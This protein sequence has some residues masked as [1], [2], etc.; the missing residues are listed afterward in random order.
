M[1][2]R[3]LIVALLALFACDPSL[4][5]THANTS[6]QNAG[7]PEIVDSRPDLKPS[8]ATKSDTKSGSEHKEEQCHYDGPHWFAG[9]YCFFAGHDKFWVSF[10]TLVL[11]AFTTIL[12]FATIFLTRAT[13][14]LVSGAEQ[15]SKRQ[16]RAYIGLIKH[17][18][19]FDRH[20]FVITIKNTGQTPGLRVTP[21][22]NM[23]WYAPGQQ[24]PAHFAFA[25]YPQVEGSGSV[26]ITPGQEHPWSFEI[27]WERFEEFDRGLLDYFYVYGRF[28]YVDVF[29]DRW[30]SQFCYEAVRFPNGGGA[31]RAASR[32]NDAT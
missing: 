20:E 22:F 6:S 31:F 14:R 7:Q 29:G 26:F 24:M 28:E 10:G 16:L 27:D 5:Q 13:N 11:A 30:E 21:F 4:G 12:G 15:T 8:L 25:D 19:W 2:N 17:E 18:I 3:L 23:E 1:L 9:F 32:H